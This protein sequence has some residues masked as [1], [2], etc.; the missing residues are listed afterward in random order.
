MDQL[1]STGA[2]EWDFFVDLSLLGMTVD[3]QYLAAFPTQ[4]G[5]SILF[6]NPYLQGVFK[7]K[8]I[9][10][11]VT[12]L[13]ICLLVPLSS[14]LYADTP[15]VKELI[16]RM[17]HDFTEHNTMDKIIRSVIN[18]SN[19]KLKNALSNPSDIRPFL[20]SYN[21]NRSK[22]HSTAN[23]R[24]SSPK[25]LLEDYII[26]S[27]SNHKET[28]KAKE[29]LKNNS[30]VLW[31]GE[32][33][34]INLS[35]IPNDP[36][37]QPPSVQVGPGP[38]ESEYQ[39][40]L[41]SLNMPDAWDYSRGHA[42][43]SLI[44]LGIQTD[45][46]DILANFRDRFSARIISNQI[47]NS[48]GNISTH[49]NLNLSSLNVDEFSA[50]LSSGKNI[51]SLVRRGFELR[52][53]HGM[54][55]AGIIA[56][57]QDN[58]IGVTGI[59]GDCS[60]M[61]N[62]TA[63]V[64]A[65]GTR[66]QVFSYLDGQSVANNIIWLTDTGTQ[67]INMSFSLNDLAPENGCSGYTQL[68]DGSWIRN[69]MHYP[70]C[71]AIH[72]ADMYDV[73][74]I[75]AS[76]NGSSDSI[77][78][79]ASHPMVIAVGAVNSSGVKPAWSN[80]GPEIDLVAP[81]ENILSTVYTDRT[82][83]HPDDP[84]AFAPECGDIFSAQPGY[85]PCSGT[86]MSTPH[87][88]GIA[89]ILRSINPL[90]NKRQIK[91]LLTEHASQEGVHNNQVGYGIPDA[92]ASV[93]S[94]MGIVNGR[95]LQNRL[96]PLFSLYSSDGEDH[97]YTTV[98]QM[99]MAAIY[100][101]LRPQPVTENLENFQMPYNPVKWRSSGG[102]RTPGYYSFPYIS[103]MASEPPMASVYIFTTND[104]PL[105]PAEPENESEEIRL[106]PLYRLSY[107]GNYTGSNHRNID[108]TYT[109]EQAGF[110]LF[111]NY[112]IDGIEGYIYPRT[113]PTQ[114]PGTVKLYRKYNPTRD[115]HA[116]FPE[117]ELSTMIAQG[118]THNSGDDWIGYV[119]PNQDSD[120]DL[121]IDGFEEIIGTDS[122]YRDSD[123]DGLLDGWEL[124]YYFTDP[125]G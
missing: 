53:G 62:H 34:Y 99:A 74:M 66:K 52:L 85:G 19:Q 123:S 64:T 13:F 25:V 75:A 92:T 103:W 12:F 90:L 8:R 18:G 60:L 98:P 36:L 107:Q 41:E 67:L 39:W 38:N 86:S 20:H 114:P 15:D 115:D 56:A 112:K 22:T 3:L 100:G 97:L 79:P 106:V 37:S 71:I 59:C 78:F 94:A 44:D 104:N 111:D 116:I 5:T 10:P 6:R 7:M 49:I 118:Y 80:T 48:T 87:V 26:L 101:S 125:L 54:H 45:H 27:Y 21:R 42:Y 69:D 24:N 16:V 57:K 31:I 40:A 55:V 96:T 65:S 32:N 77:D 50:I 11:L 76:G 121:L 4:T 89:A 29:I 109:T 2:N 108:H 68:N 117:T 95:V 120:R 102:S 122:T 105:D 84:I 30:S 81:G 73:M 9:L 70:M 28:K 113:M 46:P 82:W 119:Y 110:D 83:L 1:K 63:K 72:H 124:I 33:T 43:V 88:T 17:H 61:V 14:S 58:S 23:G 93:E 35:G 47:V 91:D 51:D